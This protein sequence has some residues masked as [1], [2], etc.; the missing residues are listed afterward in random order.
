MGQKAPKFEPAGAAQCAGL[1]G[2][3]EAKL[4][5]S[6][7][8]RRCGQR[9]QPAI[10]RVIVGAERQDRQEGA[11]SEALLRRLEVCKL[12][13]CRERRCAHRLTLTNV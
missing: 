10:D 6:E 8:R 5:V 3:S 13:R 4:S 2:S 9:G 7:A 11:A 1:G 12:E